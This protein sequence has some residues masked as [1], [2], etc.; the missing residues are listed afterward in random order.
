[1]RLLIV[2]DE[3]DIAETLR[4]LLELLGYEVDLAFDGADALHKAEQ[5]TPDVILTDAMMPL[6]TGPELVAHLRQRPALAQIPVILMS[7]A[8]RAEEAAQLGAWFLRKP[9]EVRE[10]RAIIDEL[11]R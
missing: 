6:V 8:L 7:A 5:T 11:R 4:D 1:M 2:D 9:F 3:V 10:L